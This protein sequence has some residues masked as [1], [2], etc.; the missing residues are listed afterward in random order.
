[1]SPLCSEYTR[2]RS[3]FGRHNDRHFDRQYDR[4][5]DRRDDRLVYSLH[6][7]RRK[8][9]RSESPASSWAYVEFSR[10]RIDGAECCCPRPRDVYE[11]VSQLS[12]IH[13]CDISTS[14]LLGTRHRSRPRADCG[15]FDM[16][17]SLLDRFL[18]ERLIENVVF[19]TRNGK[20]R[21]VKP[22]ET[23]VDH[24]CRCSLF[25][26]LVLI[27]FIQM[28]HGKS[29]NEWTKL[30][31]GGQWSD[32][33]TMQ[34]TAGTREGERTLR[35]EQLA[36]AGDERHMGVVDVD[37]RIDRPTDRR[38]VYFIS[39]HFA[40]AFYR[41]TSTELY[42]TVIVCRDW[43]T[44]RSRQRRARVCTTNCVG[45]LKY[46]KVKHLKWFLSIWD[47]SGSNSALTN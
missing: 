19:E 16:I 5:Y 46:D 28:W 42:H 32:M 3:P 35:N 44:D 9:P 13:E 38:A 29:M 39:F 8:C 43:V 1:M 7:W 10:R 27:S 45:E 2:R 36:R 11:W 21:R 23:C 47:C 20:S 22:E 33:Q 31:T 17:C 14:L 41:Q 6:Y 40:S 18:Y 37:G 24:W 34:W 30:V 4:H 25:Y 15:A 12:V 26:Y